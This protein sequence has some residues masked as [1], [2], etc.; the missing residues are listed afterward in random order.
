MEGG[1]ISIVSGETDMHIDVCGVCIDS[2][3][4]GERGREGREG[5]R[6]RAGGEWR[7]VLY[8]P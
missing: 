7:V 3:P 8:L 4:R 1:T 2:T 5:G 6:E